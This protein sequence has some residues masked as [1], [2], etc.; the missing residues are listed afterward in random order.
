MIPSRI[1]KVKK[2]ILKIFISLAVDIYDEDKDLTDDS[3]PVA[4]AVATRATQMV[5]LLSR[6]NVA[7][8][9]KLENVYLKMNSMQMVNKEKIYSMIRNCVMW[10]MHNRSMNITSIPD[11][12]PKAFAPDSGGEPVGAKA[13]GTKLLIGQEKNKQTRSFLQ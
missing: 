11:L 6:D 3:T 8:R 9:E 4:S 1:A 5:E 2:G 10:N 12:D 7:L 13:L